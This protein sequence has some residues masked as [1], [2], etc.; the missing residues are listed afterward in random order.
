MTPERQ[1][2]EAID[3]A[4]MSGDVRFSITGQ[5]AVEA[6]SGAG[7]VIVTAEKAAQLLEAKGTVS[8]DLDALEAAAR[9]AH[10]S[11]PNSPW[12]GEDEARHARRIPGAAAMTQRDDAAE[13]GAGI[14]ER[15]RDAAGDRVFDDTFWGRK[16]LPLKEAAAHIE[17]QAAEIARLR[18]EA[19]RFH[20]NLE[21][22]AALANR[23]A[24]EREA[25]RAALPKAWEA[26]RDACVAETD[27]TCADRAA[28]LRD[29]AT[30]G[31]WKSAL[32]C[33]Y[34]TDCCAL[35]AARLAAL[36]PPPDLAEQL[37]AQRETKG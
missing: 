1:A 36:A 2:A 16:P 24:N 15:L 18:A 22:L 13:Q 33:T 23:Y 25:A 10:R 17:A 7:L 19:M 8:P 29:L 27:C 4:S 35:Q 12:F 31:T 28:V 6:I 20:S 14:V 9:A 26:G 5:E 37:T 32:R 34:G 3:R 11:A 21:A 30:D